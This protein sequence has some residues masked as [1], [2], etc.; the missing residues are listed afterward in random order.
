MWTFL[1]S[2]ILLFGGLFAAF[3]V[4]RGMYAS[5][6]AEAAK[7]TDLLY[8]TL[9]TAILLTSSL[10]MALAVESALIRRRKYV[11]RYLMATVCWLSLF[12]E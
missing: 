12:W 3:A 4:Y 5:A 1:A 6:F 9:N 10:T 7:R 11:L 2:E 8:G